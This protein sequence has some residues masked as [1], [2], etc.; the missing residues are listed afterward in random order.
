[1]TTIPANATS[2]RGKNLIR[3]RALDYTT[4]QRRVAGSKRPERAYLLVQVA[5]NMQ[6]QD[7]NAAW[8]KY[9]EEYDRM[10]QMY[11]QQMTERHAVGLME[12]QRKLQQELRD[13]PPKWSKVKPLAVVPL[14]P[15]HPSACTLGRSTPLC[16]LALNTH[17]EHA[18][19]GHAPV[20]FE[21][22]SRTL[23][24]FR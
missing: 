1:M 11:V 14:V 18:N 20:N 19:Y 10:A 24:L 7:F 17:F 23:E 5:H 12:H 9:L 15:T 13:K 21:V 8:N 2:C 6:F 3:S 4:Q 16:V 22:F